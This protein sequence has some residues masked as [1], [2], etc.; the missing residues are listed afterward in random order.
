[1]DEIPQPLWL[2]FEDFLVGTPMREIRL[3]CS[4]KAIRANRGRLLSGHPTGRITTDDVVAVLTAARGR[5]RYCGSLAVQAAPTH[6]VSRKPMPWG[7]I[8]RRIGSLD[9]VVAR[10]DGG[11]NSVGNLCWCCHWCNTWPSER[12]P[13]AADH[14]AVQPIS[15]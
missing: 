10:I 14:G 8:G 9:H 4:R 12:I 7:H 13:G 15:S 5:C 2:S 3:W 11:R 1:M 6:P